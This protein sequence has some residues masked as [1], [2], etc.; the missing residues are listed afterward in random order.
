MGWPRVP[1]AVDGQK[2]AFSVCH[3]RSINS[4]AFSPHSESIIW[5]EMEN[6]LY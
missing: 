5:K 1:R 2:M 4:P 6:I 3:R